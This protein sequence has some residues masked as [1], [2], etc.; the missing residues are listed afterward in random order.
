MLIFKHISGTIMDKIGLS[1]ISLVLIFNMDR[2]SPR[3]MLYAIV[4]L[5][6]S[7][8]SPEMS[9]ETG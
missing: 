8:F 7:L 5:N 2:K 1:V 3:F 6:T 4:N 9:E